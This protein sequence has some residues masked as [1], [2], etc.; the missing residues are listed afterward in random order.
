MV[1]GRLCDCVPQS[2]TLHPLA[3][4][5]ESLPWSCLG[6]C[7]GSADAVTEE[8]G[9]P[10]LAASRTQWEPL[11]DRRQWCRGISVANER[12]GLVWALSFL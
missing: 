5:G 12:P 7:Q 10:T 11:R 2:P 4:V 9:R 3:S 8:H 6:E 1:S